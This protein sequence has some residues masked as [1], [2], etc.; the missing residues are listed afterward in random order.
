M[1]SEPKLPEFL[2]KVVDRFEGVGGR[3]RIAALMRPAELCMKPAALSAMK[4]TRTSFARVLARHMIRDRW[5]VVAREFTCDAEGDARAIYDIS[6]GMHQLTYIA[7]MFRWDGV[8]KVGRRS[9]GAYRDMLGAVFLGTP[10][11]GR[12][13]AE[14]LV[15]ESRDAD[16][17]RTAGDVAGWTPANRSARFFDYVTDRLTAGLQPD[18]AVI[19]NGAGYLLRNGGYLG[20][21]RYGT[22]SL[23]GF[24]P[25]HPLAHPF[26]GDLFGLLL[27][28]QV[29]IDLVNAIAAARSPKAARMAPEIARYIGV[30][31]SSGQG[32][33]VA[34]QRWPHWVATWMVVREVS[35]A[36]AKAQ[37]LGP[38]AG[39]LKE[40][41][42]RAI[43]Y[44]GSV[45]VP[46]EVFIVPHSVIITDLMTA[47]GWVTEAA[48]LDGAT[49]WAAITDRAASLQTESAEQLNS[50]LIEC[51]PEFADAAADYLPVGVA[52][53]RRATRDD[54]RGPAAPAARPLWLGAAD[55]SEPLG[56]A[57]ALLVSLR[58]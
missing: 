24:P 26:F 58:R 56:R 15:L 16:T 23:E 33:C 4:S 21:G 6:I 39:R 35:L 11:H 46:N 40:L 18:P 28:R 19:G 43:D 45:Q 13:E 1:Q 51:Y 30:G 37:P 3:A 12:I 20:S 36:Y 14:F 7:R 2:G 38:R 31:N 54:G 32:M 10:D 22:S 53:A 8:E 5:K 17:M 52:R 41:L 9:D 42:D 44:Y 25:G 55:G 47:A 29:S 27:V 50:L 34:L 49:L 57:S 48:D